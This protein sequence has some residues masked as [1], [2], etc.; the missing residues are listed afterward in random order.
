MSKT[1]KS[2]REIALEVIYQV[3]EKGAYTNLT[4]E[5]ALNASQ[6]LPTDRHLLTEIVNGTVR[7]KL[8]L[9]WVLQQYLR[10]SLEKLNPW[11]KNIL[12]L[13][14]YQLL[15]MDKIPTYAVVN[16]AVELTRQKTGKG[17][18]GLTNGVL[19]NIERNKDKIQIAFNAI[20]DPLEQAS[21]KHSLPLFLLNELKAAIPPEDQSAVYDF[22]NQV[23]TVWLR[24][25]TLK[26]NRDA[27]QTELLKE[28]IHTAIDARIPMALQ[29]KESAMPLAET[30]PFRR[31]EFYLQNP[32]SMLA[33]LALKPKPGE[34]VY[35]LCCG[36]GG[37]STHLA[38][39]MQ[40]TGKII[41]VERYAH[42]LNLLQHNA[43]RLGIINIEPIL[44]DLETLSLTKETADK[45]L[46]DVPCS[47]W[48]VLNRRADLRWHQSE[49][50]L[51]DLI[52]LQSTLLKNAAGLVKPGGV[53]LYVTCTFRPAENEERI[54]SFLES[55]QRFMLESLAET[56]D[57]FP[58]RETEK[59]NLERGSLTHYPGL[60]EMDGMY[61]AKLRR[62][63]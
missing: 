24:V 47:G 25:N 62:M 37:K 22:W 1:Q 52:G 28:G 14:V 33:S 41:A 8:Y 21:I 31:G 2:V 13:A 29:L 19:R 49:S 26:T 3:L 35:D 46:L 16:E 27:L 23:P 40:N 43:E 56:L 45:V 34:I 61:Y 7:Q 51:S 59:I 39:L 60:Y 15:L 38:E 12:R 50:M 5:K 9:D 36:V 10:Q 11:L 53:L 20:A 18:T 44:G 6:L 48:G 4:L 58:W 54:R 55:D 57:F 63:Q 42:K 17:L 30:R 32:A